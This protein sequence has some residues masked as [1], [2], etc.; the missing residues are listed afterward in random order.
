MGYQ[1]LSLEE[2]TTAGRENPTFAMPEDEYPGVSG[3]LA[4]L[5]LTILA[6]SHLTPQAALEAGLNY[7]ADQGLTL[8]TVDQASAGAMY[9]FSKDA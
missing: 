5:G 3:A 7:Y 8:V 4:R 2:V 1:V 6:K 9:V